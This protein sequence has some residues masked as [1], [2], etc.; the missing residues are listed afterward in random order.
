M[1]DTL[2]ASGLTVKTLQEIV[3]E[4]TDGMKGIYGDDINVDQN[5]PDGQMINIYSKAGVDIRELIMNVYNSFDPDRASGSVLD[6]RVVI[7]NIERRGGTFTL[8]PISI[9]VDST[10]TLAGLDGDFNDV[11]ATGYTVQDNAGNQFILQNTATITAGTHVLNFR[12]QKIGLVT[13]TLNTITNQVTIVLGVTSVNNPSAALELG[14]NEET[15]AQ[16]RTRRSKSPSINSIGFLG[17]LLAA[18]LELDGVSD[19][20]IYQNVTDTTDADGIPGHGIWLI[21]EGGDSDDIGNTIYAKKSAGSNMKGAQSLSII[22]P[23]GYPFVVKWDVPTAQDLYVR[24]DIQPIIVGATFDLV[25][26]KNY[27][28]TNL[29]YGI[30]QFAETASITGIAL[31][32]IASAGGKGVPVNVEVSS[33]GI[34]Y[35]D[36]LATSTKDK[37][38]TLASSRIAITPL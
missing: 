10:V 21:V 24:F 35:V 30:G 36:Y 2:D 13:P 23:S 8:Q 38:F 18:I 6:E 5:S 3:T 27:I 22:E 14:Q 7:N 9:V 12:A 29:L 32:A 16:L 26:I 4:L 15:D 28:V 31:D 17:G 19:A 25:A 37:K 1:P 34:T 11:S 33:D 20:E